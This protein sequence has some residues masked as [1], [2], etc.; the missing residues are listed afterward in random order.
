MADALQEIRDRA[1][2]AREGMGVD[3]SKIEEDTLDEPEDTEETQID[4]PEE[5]V[6]PEPEETE[7]ESEE[8]DETE[9]D[10]GE[11]DT[12]PEPQPRHTS[13]FKQLNK[14]RTEKRES[15]ANL[16]KVLDLVGAESLEDA[17]SKIMELRKSEPLSDEFIQAAK[18]MG[19]E[20][21]TALK[22]LATLVATQVKKDIDPRLNPLSERLE[23]FSKTQE[24]VQQERELQESIAQ[25][26]GEWNEL[27]PMIESM[28]KPSAVQAEKAK[29]LMLQLAHSE[30]YQDK[31]LDY[32]LYKEG[33]QFESILGAPK[34]KTMLP[35]RG[36]KPQAIIEEK[37]GTLPKPDGTHEG[38]LKARAK[39]REMAS[40]RLDGSTDYI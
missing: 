8:P 20:D 7:E 40:Q 28:Y 34:R 37:P 38:F 21:P 11:D 12:E 9:E 32:I 13:V 22:T 10:T 15:D 23:S 3:E 31:E 26:T 4:E 6:T 36:Q 27:L 18:E 16:R 17:E 14:I 1:A 29:E 2:Q 35:A 19:I 24:A 25:A 39:M 5:E 33:D 30:K